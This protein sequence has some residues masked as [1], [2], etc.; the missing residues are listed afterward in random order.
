MIAGAEAPAARRVAQAVLVV[1]GI[2]Q[3][4]ASGLLK[5]RVHLAL[6]PPSANCI[7][8]ALAAA[9]HVVAGDLGPNVVRPKGVLS[10]ASQTA[11]VLQSS[12]VVT[13]V[14]PAPR[15]IVQVI[16]DVDVLRAESV[17]YQLQCVREAALG[18]LMGAHV[19][20]SDALALQRENPVA[21][22]VAD[23]ARR[24]RLAPGHQR[25]G[26]CR[27]AFGPEQVG[28]LCKEGGF[29][30]GSHLAAP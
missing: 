9:L 26:R 3:P 4:D 11:V 23:G 25:V 28:Q 1:A 29:V 8:Q 13:T 20:E 12:L 27:I 16:D 18:L 2:D 6:Q 21:V 7:A 22:R 5:H 17:F 10:G 30:R 15:Q 24:R 19:V 14:E